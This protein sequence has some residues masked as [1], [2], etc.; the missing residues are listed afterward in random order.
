[1]AEELMSQCGFCGEEINQAL[2]PLFINNAKKLYATNCED[3]LTGPIER[4]DMNTVIK[5]F[6]VLDDEYY[7]VYKLISRELVKIA[8]NKN[9][10][11]DYSVLLDF[12]SDK[13]GRF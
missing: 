9:K 5:H 7:E 1:M 10:D 6:S 2:K 4:C 3:A 12:L 13:K 11:K 8:C